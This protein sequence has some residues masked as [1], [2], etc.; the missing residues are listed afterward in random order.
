M[1][2]SYNISGKTKLNITTTKGGG[3]N[4]YN[5]NKISCPSMLSK[6]QTISLKFSFEI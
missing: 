5:K 1:S 3:Y 2:L 6:D 4:D